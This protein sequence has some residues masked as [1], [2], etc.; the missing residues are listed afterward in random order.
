[1]PKATENNVS[2]FNGKAQSRFLSRIST[3]IPGYSLQ[4]I[5]DVGANIGQTCVPLAQ[6]LPKLKKLLPLSQFP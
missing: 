3:A 1:M 6:A 5:V 2:M 4:S